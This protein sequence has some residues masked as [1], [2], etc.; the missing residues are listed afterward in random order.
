MFAFAEP[1]NRQNFYDIIR[2]A[3]PNTQLPARPE[4]DDCDLS[5]IA[6]RPRAL[7]LLKWYGKDGFT[8]L[9]E[10]IIDTI[11]AYDRSDIVAVAQSTEG[12]E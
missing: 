12:Q 9:G 10:S 11:D 6:E 1:Y 3:R 5:D 7:A 2:E 8:S 4:N